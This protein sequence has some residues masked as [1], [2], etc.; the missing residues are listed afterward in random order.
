MFGHESVDECHRRITQQELL[1]QSFLTN[2]NIQH[3]TITYEDLIIGRC[4]DTI[5]EQF[6]LQLADA[7][8]SSTKRQSNDLNLFLT[9]NYSAN[10]C[11][12]V[13]Q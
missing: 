8:S 13:Q 4:W 6:N 1:I 12:E 10:K 7:S 5:K 11:L 9:K 2:Y 3:S